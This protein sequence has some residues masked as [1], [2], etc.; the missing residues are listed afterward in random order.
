MLFYLLLF[1]GTPH[2]PLNGAQD[3]LNG[4]AISKRQHLFHVAV[5]L[6]L[7]LK[8]LPMGLAPLIRLHFLKPFDPLSHNK[9]LMRLLHWLYLWSFHLPAAVLKNHNIG[10]FLKRNIVFVAIPVNHRSTC[11]HCLISPK[12]RKDEAHYDHKCSK[13]TQ[14]DRIK[15]CRTLVH[16]SGYVVK[17]FLCCVCVCVQ[18]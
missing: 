7:W 1:I 18:S 10:S 8:R 5:S 6:L 3:G 17:P 15:I 4:G 14:N 11:C 9:F 16:V 12:F 2:T 13:P